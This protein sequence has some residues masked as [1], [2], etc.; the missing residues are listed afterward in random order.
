MTNK[1]FAERL[2]QLRIE[3]G[4]SARDMSLT[5]GLSA[6]YINRIENGRMMPSMSVFFDICDYFMLTPS[7]FFYIEQDASADALHAFRRLTALNKKKQD[8]V[9]SLINDL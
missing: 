3:K 4:V 7:E 2:T 9:I 6:T 5:L 1:E 8:L